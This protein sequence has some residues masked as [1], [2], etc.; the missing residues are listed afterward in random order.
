MNFKKKACMGRF[1]LD[2][3]KQSRRKTRI[4]VG[5]SVFHCKAECPC[6]RK[7]RTEANRFSK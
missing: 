3:I 1:L 7:L 5:G 6:L 2:L 4:V